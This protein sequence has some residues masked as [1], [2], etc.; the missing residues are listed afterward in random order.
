[1]EVFIDPSLPPPTLVLF[2]AG[3]VSQATAPLARRVGFEVI[4]ADELEE[5]AS[6]ERFPDAARFLHS[7]DPSEFAELPLGPRCFC[8]IATR[9]HAIDQDLLEALIG[10]ELAYL[11]VIGS[12]GKAGRFRKRLEAKGVAEAALARVRMPVGLDIAAETPE[13]IAVS[14]VAELIRVKNAKP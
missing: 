4:V 12:L 8:V 10:R 6:A 9:D 7:F 1:M 2:G 5:F 3:H 13:E 14:I 11:G